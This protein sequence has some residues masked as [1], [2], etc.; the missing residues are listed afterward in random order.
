MGWF[1]KIFKGSTQRFRLGNDHDHNGYYQSYPHD[2]PS[3]DTD[4][5]ET[6]TQEPSTSEVT[7]TVFTYL[8]LL[9]LL[10]QHFFVS[11]YQE[12]TSGQENE[13]IDRAI[14]LSL[15]E[16]SQGHT[17]TGAGESF[18]LAKLER[19]MNYET[20][21][22]TFNRIVNAGKYAMVDEDEQLARA[23]QESM[24]VGNTP[25]Q[26][27]GSS[28]D[29]GNAYGSGD[30]YGNGHMHGG[31]NVYANGDIYYPRPTA[32]PMDFRFT[33]DTQLI[34]CSLFNLVEMC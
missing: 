19:N 2:E 21:F 4:P 5:D 11:L 20:R 31:G 8:W 12:D 3:A 33:F 6:H 34:I 13:D 22:V 16:N 24:V 32:F 17:N 26:K 1:N 25:R 18:F 28:Y 30:V 14:A 29:I 9:V 10:L 15:I 7:I 27:H 23:I